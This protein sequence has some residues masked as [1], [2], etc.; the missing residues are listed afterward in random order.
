MVRYQYDARINLY[1][2]MVPAKY[3]DLKLIL[4]IKL[5]LQ[6]LDKN[7]CF[8]SEQKFYL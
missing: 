1:S 2:Y 8:Y 4:N 6:Y 3:L 7:V 5:L